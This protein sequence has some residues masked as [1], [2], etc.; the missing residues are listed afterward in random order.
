M[1]S[2][3]QAASL[4]ALADIRINGTRPWD[5]QVH[6]ERLYTRVLAGGSLALGESY[7]DGWWDAKKLDEF[8][9]HLLA[10]NIDKKVRTLRGALTYLRANLVN[11]QRKSRAHIIG[12]HH[13][14]LSN[15]LYALMLD[16]R[17]NYS[18]GYWAHATTLDEAQ[19][20]KLELICQK[21]RLRPGMRVLDIGC[22]WGAFAQYAAEKHRVSVVGITVSNEQARLAKERCKGLL[23]EIRVQDYREVDEQFDRIVSVGMI[24]HVGKK[25]YKTYFT[26]ADKCLKDG[27]LFLLQTIGSNASTSSSDPWTGKYIFPNSMLPSLKQLT[28]AVERLFIVEDIHGFGP[29]YDKTLL[30]WE[31]NFVKNWPKINR[32]ERFYRMWR[33]YLLS[34]AGS[35][36]ARHIQL[37]QLVLSKGVTHYESVR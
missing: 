21:L 1:S 5:L 6:D 3:S 24:E 13:Y 22:G 23:V 20:A 29:D 18:C 25:N 16:K 10:A 4:L 33:Y 36:R 34:S 7:M 11:L 17:M 19:E 31:H 9:A 28:G 12:R 30:A 15:E 32:G 26:V 35:F 27:G 37:W 2:T 8:F 14:D